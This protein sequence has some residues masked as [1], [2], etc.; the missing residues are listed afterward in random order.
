VK[1]TRILVDACYIHSKTPGLLDE[2][3]Q[4]FFR[5]WSV[6]RHF[7]LLHRRCD[8]V[9][10]SEMPVVQCTKVISDCGKLISHIQPQNWLPWHSNIP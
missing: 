5:V 1:Q 9:I 8:D 2:I 4:N 6:H 10:T 7:V 3:S